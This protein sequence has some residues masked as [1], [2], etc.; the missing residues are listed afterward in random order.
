MKARILVTVLLAAALAIPTFADEAADMPVTERWPSAL[1]VYGSPLA[2][3]AGGGL[4]WQTWYGPLGLSLVGGGMYLP[5][6]LYGSILDYSVFGEVQYRVIREDFSR[7][8]ASQLY[9]WALAGHLGYITVTTTY[10]YATNTATSVSTSTST[11]TVHPFVATAVGGLGIGIEATLFGHFSIPLEV[12]YI[13]QFPKDPM[14]T[15]S[16]SGGLRYRY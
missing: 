10:D 7:W 11:R 14:L 15:F 12:G 3:H 4:N 16:A 5:S 6:G 9:V 1:G 8:F 13:G 2:G